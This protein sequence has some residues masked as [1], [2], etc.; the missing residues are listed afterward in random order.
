[1]DP[2]PTGSDRGTGPHAVIT[3][4][5]D[6]VW[7]WYNDE[8][9]VFWRNHLFAGYVTTDGT[10]AV[11]AYPLP[12]TIS[13]SS[14]DELPLS[15]WKE[16]DD[17][18]NPA[19]LPLNEE[20]LLAV[21]A[22]HHTSNEF[23]TRIIKAE[24]QGRFSTGPEQAIRQPEGVTYANLFRLSQEQDR[25]YNFFRCLNFSPTVVWSDD[26]ANTWSDPLQVLSWKTDQPGNRRPYVKYASDGKGRIDLF[27]ND[28]HP[29]IV[30]NN[31]VYHLFYENG[32]FHRSD[33]QLVR[34]VADLRETGPIKTDRGTRIYDGQSEGRGWVH[35]FE[36]GPNG[37]LA[38]VYINSADGD[39]GLDLRYRYAR[40]DPVTK[41]WSEREI[42][43][44]GPHLYVPENHYAGGICL[45]P[46]DLNTVYLSSSLDPDSGEPNTTG[47]YQ[48][49]RGVTPDK[50]ETWHFEQLTFDLA[51]DNLRP[52]VP[53]DRPAGLET[54]V[55]WFRGEYNR[56]VDY[57][58]EVVGIIE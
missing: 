13:H 48:I 11:S 5:K 43:F 56:F 44:A 17:H 1:M 37:E 55:L 10:S 49:Y 35:D 4:A 40:F 58:C 31:N 15:S 50:G 33:G 18:N 24:N 42:A 54:V 39:A 46:D 47:K 34:T 38:G 23:Y 25:I 51:R 41:T 32:T 26:E 19:L 7:T 30:K 52:F 20:E 29:R 14:V 12:D 28:G 53:R 57:S 45:D 8:R 21:Y 16:V 36:R 3:V 9:A 22:M 6:G 27:F 2:S